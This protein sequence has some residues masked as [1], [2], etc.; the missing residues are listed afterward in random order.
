[1]LATRCYDYETGL[2]YGPVIELLRQATSDWGT[3]SLP[4]AVP[5]RC[6]AAPA[7]TRGGEGRARPVPARRSRSAGTPPRR[8]DRRDQRSL[9]RPPAGSRARGRRPRRG[10]RHDRCHR[11]PRPEVGRTRAPARVDL[12]ERGGAS[13]PPLRRLAVDLARAPDGHDREPGPARRGRR[14]CAGSRDPP[15]GRRPRA[16]ARVHLES[17]GLPLFVAEYLAALRV[18]GAGG[19]SVW[20]PARRAS[21]GLSDVAR[22]SWAPR[23]RSAARSTSRPCDRRAAAATR[24][25]LQR[26]RRLVTHGL[27]REA[28]GPEPGYDFS[29]AKLRALAYEQTGLAR[30]RL[31]HARMAAALSMRRPP[32][33]ER[34]ARRPAS[35]SGGRSRGAA[36]PHRLAAEYAAVAPRPCRR[37]RPSRGGP[38][39][40]IPGCRRLTSGSATCSRF[41]A[42]TAALLSSYERAAAGGEPPPAR[43]SSTS[44]ATSTTAAANG[45][46]AE[47]RFLPRSPQRPPASAGCGH[48][49]RPTWP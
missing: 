28:A 44:L 25:P 34:R 20:R 32:G 47:A 10:R 31:L 24:R 7:P 33:R 6:L 49:S 16:R 4:P 11:L 18:G 46:A 22:R 3:E 41:W 12:A 8:R 40:R 43:R 23:R 45:S 19:I 15:G 30:R 29:H 39:P 42:T 36:E 9:P 35:G 13:R 48:G 1:M 26:S 14:G 2:P 5:R 17:E 21:A 27:V 37:A 38:R